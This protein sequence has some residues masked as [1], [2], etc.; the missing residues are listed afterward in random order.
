[1]SSMHWMSASRSTKSENSVTFGSYTLNTPATTSPYEIVP[2][3]LPATLR[4][5]P[6][7]ADAC[8]DSKIGQGRE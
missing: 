5:A 2:F 8:S 1:M 4:S 6:P 3:I 7:D